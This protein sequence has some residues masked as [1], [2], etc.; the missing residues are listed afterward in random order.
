MGTFE[1]DTTERSKL[2]HLLSDF[3][4]DEHM[5]PQDLSNI[6]ARCAESK[7]TVAEL[8][9]IMFREVY[10]ALIQNLWAP[11]GEWVPWSEEEVATRV[12]KYRHEPTPVRWWQFITWRSWARLRRQ[13]EQLRRSREHAAL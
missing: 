5:T 12:H 6:A 4:L 13:V 7:Y 11:V 1:A 8:D 10:P 9:V 2:W 3:Y